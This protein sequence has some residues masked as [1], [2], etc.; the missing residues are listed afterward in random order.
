MKHLSHNRMVRV[1][2]VVVVILLATLGMVWG[3]RY[4]TQEA[5]R[6]RGAQARLDA[7]PEER[8]KTAAL[9]SEI[10]KRQLDIQRVEAFIL[11]KEAL[12]AAVAS[13]E[14]A[15]KSRGFTVTVPAV[16]EK[17]NLDEDGDVMET[18]GPLFEVRLKVVATGA[19]KQLLSFLHDIEHAQRLTYLESF[20][21]D[22]A[23]QTGRNQAA[24]LAGEKNVGQTLPAILTADII[25][26][27]RKETL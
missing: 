24:T 1:S 20:R 21:L 17:Q 26:G 10:N 15:G 13:I 11:T 8:A 22:A 5:A 7:Q 2:L 18:K 6:V 4:V 19:P 14:E 3:S 23:E 16:E 27:V 9:Q 12:S 25:I